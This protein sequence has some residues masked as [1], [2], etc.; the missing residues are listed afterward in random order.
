MKKYLI[1]MLM[2]AIVVVQGEAQNVT[3]NVMVPAW[4]K[5]VR[6]NREGVNL[7]KAPNAQSARLMVHTSEVECIYVS[8]LS[9]TAGA[10]KT[11]YNLQKDEVVP[12]IGIEGDWYHIYI[13]GFDNIHD[14]YIRRDFCSEVTPCNPHTGDWIYVIGGTN[15]SLSVEEN[16]LDEDFSVSVGRQQR[17]KGIVWT[18]YPGLYE[19]LMSITSGDSSYL[20]QRMGSN[21]ITERQLNQ[22]INSHEGFETNSI[23]FTF[24]APEGGFRTFTYRF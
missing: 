20:S 4:E 5:F 12:V 10:G 19:Y 17:N 18:H 23:T 3:Q 21:I 15:L 22:F 9:W 8:T 16:E 1:L 14:A 6:V 2:L 11:P 24:I 13:S 7:R